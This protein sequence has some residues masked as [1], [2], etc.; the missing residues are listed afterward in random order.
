MSSRKPVPQ[1]IRTVKQTEQAENL[2]KQQTKTNDQK[3]MLIT[4][5]PNF[6]ITLVTLAWDSQQI[7]SEI[8]MQLQMLWD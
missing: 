5:K 4:D 7:L 6:C 1:T 3:H 8:K 2:P